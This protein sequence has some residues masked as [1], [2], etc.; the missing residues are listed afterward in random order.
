LSYGR[1]SCYF[2]SLPNCIS[3]PAFIMCRY[4]TSQF[5]CLATRNAPSG[6][7]ALRCGVQIRSRRI[8]EPHWVPI[9][10]HLLKNDSLQFG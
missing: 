5:A 8:C 10:A 2:T 7:P 4:A 6:P 1:M 3:G 9:P